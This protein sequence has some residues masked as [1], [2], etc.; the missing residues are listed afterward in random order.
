M[1]CDQGSHFRRLDLP[2]CHGVRIRDRFATNEDDCVHPDN[3]PIFGVCF[4]ESNPNE[5]VE[6]SGSNPEDMRPFGGEITFP[7]IA[8]R[9]TPILGKW[10][11]AKEDTL[12]DGKPALIG[13]SIL[14]CCHGGIIGFVDDGQGVG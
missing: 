3:V 4:S 12:V 1:V 2:M 13:R 9:C 5:L 14:V 8:K 11:Y 10:L 6:Y 7:I